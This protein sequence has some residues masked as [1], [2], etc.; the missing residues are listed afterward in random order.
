MSLCPLEM[1]GGL[2]KLEHRCRLSM[3]RSLSVDDSEQ[4]VATLKT[5]ALREPLPQVLD[6]VFTTTGPGYDIS[7]LARW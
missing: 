1:L 3:D 5:V 4:T 6:K 7:A 2:H